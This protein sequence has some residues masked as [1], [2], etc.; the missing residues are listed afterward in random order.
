M[1]V[2]V[3]NNI[4]AD[5][6][7]DELKEFLARYGFPPFDGIERIPGDGFMPA[8]VLTFEGA[9]PQMLRYLQPRV[10]NLFWNNRRLMVQVLTDRAE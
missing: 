7:D 9:D 6:S 1:T 4:K 10:H 5:I 2:L 8:A 3:I